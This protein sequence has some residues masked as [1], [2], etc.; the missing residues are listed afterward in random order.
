MYQ[1][2]YFKSP[3]LR[4]DARQVEECHRQ[5]SNELHLADGKLKFN[6]FLAMH[7]YVASHLKK[8]MGS[9]H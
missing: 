2:Y 6:F 8:F 9:H 7:M 5:I 1:T 3:K 4:T